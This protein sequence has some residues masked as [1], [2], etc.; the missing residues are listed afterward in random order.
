MC[1]KYIGLVHSSSGIGIVYSQFLK[2]IFFIFKILN[3][4]YIVSVKIIPN[5]Q[6][7]N[8]HLVKLKI[9]SGM[10]AHSKNIIIE[11]LSIMFINLNIL[12]FN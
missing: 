4:K 3:I 11:I 6:I 9:D 12:I 7:S 5:N 2:V 8:Q 10:F 1:N